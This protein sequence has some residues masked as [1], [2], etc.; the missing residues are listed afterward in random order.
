ML[1]ARVMYFDWF[2]RYNTKRPHSSL[3]DLPPS[4][5]AAL[6]TKGPAVPASTQP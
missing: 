4:M 6:M 1:E 3:G 2:D 5:F